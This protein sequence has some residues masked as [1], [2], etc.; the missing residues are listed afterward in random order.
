MSPLA[1]W[2]TLNIALGIFPIGIRILL[3]IS[4]QRDVVDLFVNTSDVLELCL[5]VSITTLA[6]LL[7]VGALV[8]IDPKLRDK[9]LYLVGGLGVF[10]AVWF[11]IQEASLLGHPEGSDFRVNTWIAAM[12]LIVGTVWL[13]FSAERVINSAE[14][15]TRKLGGK[16]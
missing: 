12:V 10:A 9:F 15:K 14:T 13:C 3:R 11:G 6:D 8:E 5:I 2:F 4:N 1:R 7:R 16:Q